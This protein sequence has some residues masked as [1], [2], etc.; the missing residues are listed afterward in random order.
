MFL[1]TTGMVIGKYTRQ[2]YCRA[3]AGIVAEGIEEAEEGENMIVS[4]PRGE[5][6]HDIEVLISRAGCR[7][8]T[9]MEP[10][11]QTRFGE[12]YQ[13]DCRDLMERMNAASVDL[14]FADPPFNLGKDY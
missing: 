14:I 3:R 9:S 11:L 10:V 8:I 4:E 7:K 12:L 2:A 5:I 13:G 1:P 6:P